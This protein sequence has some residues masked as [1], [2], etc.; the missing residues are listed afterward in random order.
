M[1]MQL[2]MHFDEGLHGAHASTFFSENFLSQTTEQAISSFCSFILGL[3]MH[4]TCSE[5][6]LDLPQQI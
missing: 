3:R 1:D 2:D 4:L 6:K 5:M